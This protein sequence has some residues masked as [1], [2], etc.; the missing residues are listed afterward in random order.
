MR[1]KQ[2]LSGV[3]RIKREANELHELPAGTP[4]PS[5]GARNTIQADGRD[6]LLDLMGGGGGD[7]FAD[8]A[9][10]QLEVEDSGGNPLFSPSSADSGYPDLGTQKQATWQWT[11][12]STDSYTVDTVRF[13][14]LGESVVFSEVTGG[15]F[16]DNQKPSTENWTYEYTLIISAGDAELQD[17][18]LHAVLEIFTGEITDSFNQNGTRI[19]PVDS[20]S[21]I[22]TQGPDSDPTRSGNTLEWVFTVAEGSLTGSWDTV[23]ILGATWASA[24]VTLS[25]GSGPG[26]KDSDTQRVYTYTFT[27]TI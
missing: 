10:S 11:D 9:S 14:V 21:P 2:S 27:L 5:M 6:H 13:T 20:G 22:G 4:L 7:N 19:E 8:N 1:K 23:N 16:S 17:D 25:S 12:A 18:G 24:D 15:P 26:T 3:W